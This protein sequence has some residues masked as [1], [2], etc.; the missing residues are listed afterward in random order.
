[1]FTHFSW[2][3]AFS[4]FFSLPRGLPNGPYRL[5]PSP[6]CL[7]QLFLFLL[8]FGQPPQ[9]GVHGLSGFG[10][11]SG[12]AFF[13]AGANIFLKSIEIYWN[14]ISQRYH[15]NDTL[16]RQRVSVSRA[17]HCAQKVLSAS[18]NRATWTVSPLEE[19]FVMCFLGD[20]LNTMFAMCVVLCFINMRSKQ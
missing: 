15:S 11:E 19:L 14:E 9:T 3:S 17:W 20:V 18:C 2:E 13:A 10:V 1:M 8:F 4:W 7:S 12:C 6:L 5:Q 16:L